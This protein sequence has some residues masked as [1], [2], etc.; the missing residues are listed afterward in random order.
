MA[1]MSKGSST[2]SISMHNFL[3]ATFSSHWRKWQYITVVLAPHL[4]NGGAGTLAVLHHQQKL[5]STTFHENDEDEDGVLPVKCIVSSGSKRKK[6]GPEGT[7]LCVARSPMKHSSAR[8]A[9]IN[10]R[11]F[12]IRCSKNISKLNEGIILSFMHFVCSSFSPNFK[13]K[14]FLFFLFLFAHERT[15]SFWNTL[16]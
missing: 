12:S 11:R 8:H 15:Q 6:L 7:H 10:T 13:R 1:T 16:Q 5:S 2:K 3:R 9:H 4:F 14:D